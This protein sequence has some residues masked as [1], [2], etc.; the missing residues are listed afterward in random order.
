MARLNSLPDGRVKVS[1]KDVLHGISRSVICDDDGDAEEF[2]R[3]VESYPGGDTHPSMWVLRDH[4][5]EYLAN[6]LT[7]SVIYRIERFVNG[8]DN[9]T[10]EER[11]ALV[12]GYLAMF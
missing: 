12:R 11:L 2:K 4:D 5:L 3:L 9:G 1:W 8:P 10:A 7:M 6:K